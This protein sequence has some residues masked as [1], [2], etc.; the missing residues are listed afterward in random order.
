[1]WGFCF[2]SGWLGKGQEKGMG[3]ANVTVVVDWL[4]L[5]DGGVSVPVRKR[6]DDFL[7]VSRA[8]AKVVAERVVDVAE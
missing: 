5:D 1:M 8:E 4:G 7:M 6:M 2:V 3:I